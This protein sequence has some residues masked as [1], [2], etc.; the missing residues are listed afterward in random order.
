MTRISEKSAKIVR[1]PKCESDLVSI[2]PMKLRGVAILGVLLGVVM[3]LLGSIFIAM[4]MNGYSNFGAA[5]FSFILIGGFG[6]LLFP[7]ILML[8]YHNHMAHRCD[9]CHHKWYKK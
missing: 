9:Q 5:G 7:I 2:K 4:A 3:L 8:Y 6:I 1:C